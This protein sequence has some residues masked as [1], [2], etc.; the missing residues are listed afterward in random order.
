MLGMK[1]QVPIWVMDVD[2][3]R[4]K[5]GLTYIILIH[6]TTLRTISFILCID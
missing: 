5:G 3:H 4:Y 1:R 6:R 2:E